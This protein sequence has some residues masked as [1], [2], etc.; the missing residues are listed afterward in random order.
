[1]AP[2]T[3]NQEK[4]LAAAYDGEEVFFHV[5]RRTKNEEGK[6]KVKSLYC[7][8]RKCKAIKVYLRSKA[9]DKPQIRKTL[10]EVKSASDIYW[11]V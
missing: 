4:K 9:A 5:T 8:R 10:V 11:E 7:G 3:H 1:M 2:L 6:S